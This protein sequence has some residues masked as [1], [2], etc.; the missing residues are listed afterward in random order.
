[1]QF[2]N[3]FNSDC[4]TRTDI[5]QRLWTKHDMCTY[6]KKTVADILNK[7]RDTFNDH[8][9]SL[10]ALSLD[11]L[12]TVLL[13]K[14]LCEKFGNLD[15]NIIFEFPTIDSLSEELLRI[16]NRQ[17][18]QMSD[19]PEHYRETEKIID[20]YVNLMEKH[21]NKEL[22]ESNRIVNSATNNNQAE[23]VVL[24]T[25]ANG[26]LGSQIFLQLLNESQVS[27]IYCLLRGE[28]AANRLR[29]D[30]QAR[31]Q[32]TTVLQNTSRV[33]ILSMD[34][35]DN[36]LG[37]STVMY[38]QLQREVTDIIHSAWKMDFNLSIK[39]FDR[40]CLQGLY[41]LLKLAS[42]SSSQIP[43]R[44]HFISSIASAGSG[45]LGEVKEEPL[46]RRPGIALAQGYGQSKYA[47]EHICWTAMNHWG[48]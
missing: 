26:S 43:M 22:V 15:L 7:P 8:S 23:R 27:R 14:T 42:S 16:V 19:D 25:G 20:K 10:Y 2:L 38:E 30:M 36:Q 33:I 48:K 40:E 46:P 21:S 4:N 5:Q 18:I 37:Q 39:D 1:M 47:G 29:N 9:Q 45:L 11:S 24:I 32:D 44:F 12:T 41:Q 17:Q 28:D 34:L 3:E 35:T 13:R 6:L 31:K